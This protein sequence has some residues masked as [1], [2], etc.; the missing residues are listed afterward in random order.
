MTRLFD[1]L[2]AAPDLAAGITSSALIS[3]AMIRVVGEIACLQQLSLRKIALSYS[4]W[5]A[6]T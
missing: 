5:D 1:V 4:N 3:M 2:H 6:L